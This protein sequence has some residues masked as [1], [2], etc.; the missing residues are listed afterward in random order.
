MKVRIGQRGLARSSRAPETVDDVDLG[1]RVMW[2]ELDGHRFEDV[3]TVAFSAGGDEIT[4]PSITLNLIGAIEMVYVGADGEP[5]PGAPAEMSIEAL[6]AIGEIGHDTVI[7][8][9]DGE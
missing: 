5:L 7:E 8:K 9:P 6:E 1:Y 2:V 3:V 4:T